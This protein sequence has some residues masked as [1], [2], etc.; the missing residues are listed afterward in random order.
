MILYLDTSA[1]AKKYIQEQDSDSVQGWMDD[2]DLVGTALITRAE[3]A[4]TLTRAIQSN[5]LPTLG[6]RQA[7]KDVRAEWQDYQRILINENLVARADALACEHNLRGYDAVHL[8]C[9]LTWQDALQT[10]VTFATF[11]G[12]LRDAAKNSGLSVLPESVDHENH[13]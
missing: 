9:A 3:I 8:A 1:L 7:L 4:S 12:Q 10:P 2:A 5:R 11:D 13:A 6:A